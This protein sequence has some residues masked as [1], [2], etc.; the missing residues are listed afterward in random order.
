MFNLV[1][2]TNRPFV[3]FYQFY[4]FT[5]AEIPAISLIERIIPMLMYTKRGYQNAVIVRVINNPL[6][7]SD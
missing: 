7:H 1:S 5:D 6:G 4:S 2:Y 3:C